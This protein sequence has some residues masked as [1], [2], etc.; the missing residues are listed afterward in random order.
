[1]SGSLNNKYIDEILSELQPGKIVG[2][3]PYFDDLTRLES[4]GNF[5]IYLHRE[6]FQSILFLLSRNDFW[7]PSGN[8]SASA[9]FILYTFPYK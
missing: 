9:I 2:N 7:T 3:N 8:V 4:R 5:I 1:M 6:N